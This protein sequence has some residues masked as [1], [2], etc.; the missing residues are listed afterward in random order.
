MDVLSP[1]QRSFNMSRIKSRD[2]KPE[3]LVRRWLWSQGYRYRL[4]RQ[5]LPG[6]PDIIL[7]R[8]HAAI[9]VHGCY[10]HRHGCKYTTT[11]S[12]RRD[13][14]LAKFAKNQKRD[15]HNIKLLQ[16]MG[17]R[18]VIVWEC[19]LKDGDNALDDV[20]NNLVAFLQND[21]PFLEIQAVPF[22]EK[23]PEH[24]PF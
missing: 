16:E 14:W 1:Q 11:P 10:W 7:P 17:W 13:F 22:E 2:T 23:A 24:F 4:H 9:F 19:S 21:M 18:V 3:M 15:Q 20:G 12:T 5:S 8:Y 6:T